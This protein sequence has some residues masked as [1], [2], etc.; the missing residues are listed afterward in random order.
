MKKE[1]TAVNSRSAYNVS[2]VT[3]C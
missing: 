3:R 2:L 1:T